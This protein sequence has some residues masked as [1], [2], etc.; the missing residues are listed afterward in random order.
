[1]VC[2]SLIDIKSSIINLQNKSVQYGYSNPNLMNSFD[3]EFG[4]DPNGF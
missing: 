1:M 2:P 4:F 3:A